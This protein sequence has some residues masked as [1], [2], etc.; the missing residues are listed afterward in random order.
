[1]LAG[2]AQFVPLGVVARQLLSF[3]VIKVT[4]GNYTCKI[5]HNYIIQPHAKN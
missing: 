2:D 1:M 3:R 5:E 4:K